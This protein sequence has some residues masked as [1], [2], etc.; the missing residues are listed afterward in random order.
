[1]RTY[2]YAAKVLEQLGGAPVFIPHEEVYTSLSQG[3]IDASMTAST[4]YKRAKYYEVAPYFSASPWFTAHG[5][6]LM[7]SSRSW[8]AL[9]D[10]LK[11]IV[12]SAVYL[13]STDIEQATRLEHEQMVSE[14]A[15][16]KTQVVTWSPEESA[17][18]RQ[19]GLQYLPEI[20]QL[21]PAVAEGVSIIKDYFGETNRS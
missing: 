7:A 2:G 21:A 13:V 20:A 6:S 11:A 5:M 19:A 4:S 3:V 17:K 14:F 16:M 18:V 12:E 10:D 1:M 15:S 9:P 8:E